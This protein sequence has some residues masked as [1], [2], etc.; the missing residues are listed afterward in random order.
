MNKN[1]KRIVAMALAIGT[2]SA[3]APATNFNLLSTKAYASENEDGDLESLELSDDDGD[4]IKLYEDSDYD[5]RIDEDEVEDGETYYAKTSSD[6]IS[7]DIDGPSDKYVKIFKGTSS[8]TKGKDVG[9]DISLSDDSTTTIVIKV[10]GEDVEDE[11]V[12]NDDDD[13]DE[14]DLQSTYKVKVKYTGDDEDSE[15]SEDSDDE[16]SDDYDDIYLEKL[17]VDGKTISLSDSKV[18]Y[19][20]DVASDV[21]EVTIKATPEDDD[22][23]VSIDGE[24]VDDDDNYK[25]T[26]DLDK[27]ANKFEIEIED[28][29][30]N[31]RVYTVTINRGTTS[32]TGTSATTTPSTATDITTAKPN[33]WIQTN[34]IWRYNDAAGNTVKNSWVQG[35]YYVQADG[36]MVTGWLSNA[37]SW[38][39]LGTNGAKQI[40]WQSVGGTWYYL[41]SQGKM[42]TGWMRDM[43]GKY[44]YLNSNGSMA[45]NTTI[46]GYKLGVT[47]AWIK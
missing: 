33:Q 1:V 45:Y 31:E 21:D 34:G 28:D 5:D 15:D 27:G 6:T 40:G 7:V 30:D 29:D 9:D 42:Q 20:Y 25:T 36:N 4:T 32:S 43:D 17:S 22:Y 19:S 13:D 8:S 46:G 23:D 3:V 2:V 11:T 35:N 14:Y 12:R 44:Y 37:G 39:Y 24:D 26:V 41:D 16:D 47:G 18:N 38:Y 10:Y